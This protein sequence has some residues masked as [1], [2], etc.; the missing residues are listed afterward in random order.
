MHQ[1][2]EEDDDD[3]AKKLSKAA[4]GGLLARKVIGNVVISLLVSTTAGSLLGGASLPQS[5][6]AAAADLSSLPQEVKTAFAQIRESEEKEDPYALRDAVKLLS[7]YP[8]LDELT[9][10]LQAREVRRQTSQDHF[11]LL[12]APHELTLLI[13]ILGYMWIISHSI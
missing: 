12:H 6:H 10:D 3:G 5:S 1:I 7:E 11:Y 8:G 13:D 9:F 4:T 2:V